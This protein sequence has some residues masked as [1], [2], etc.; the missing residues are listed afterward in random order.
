MLPA[1]PDLRRAAS[2]A[3]ALEELV[4]S[5]APEPGLSLIP[6]PTVR[7]RAERVANGA[8]H[9]AL[10]RQ[11]PPAWIVGEDARTFACALAG[12][13][14]ATAPVRRGGLLRAPGAEPLAEAMALVGP[15]DA[16]P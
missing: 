11:D 9:P 10:L 5:C 7:Q 8:D 12:I 3:F 2:L 16:R 4:R 13:L 1:D 14:A 15:R 6:N